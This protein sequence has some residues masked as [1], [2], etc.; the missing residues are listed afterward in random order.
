MLPKTIKCLPVMLAGALGVPGAQASCGSMA[1]EINPAWDIDSLAHDRG[2]RLDLRYVHARADRLRAGSARI[3]PPSPSGSGEEIEDRYTR[4]QTLAVDLDYALNRTWGLALQVPLVR[5]EHAHTLDIVPPEIQQAGYTR[6]G[7]IRVGGRYRFMA[8]DHQWGGGLRLGLKLPTGAT[9]LEMAPGEAME[10]SLQ[11]GT[12]STDA[13]LGANLHWSFP[14]SSWGGFAQLQ[15]QL[16]VD[17]RSGYEPGRSIGV[18]LGLH[19]PISETVTGLVQ[20]SYLH[21]ARD[22]GSL[23][24]PDGNSGGHATYFSPGLSVEVA[25]NTHVYGVIQVPISQY[26]NGEQLT[27]RWVASIGLRLVMD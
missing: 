16:P 18:D 1:C 6:L 5:R 8:D 17:H 7:D 26:V 11:P 12:G 2:L 14:N 15:A 9:G 23:A 25:P 21:R 3:A 24:D 22:K 10:A 13:I 27:A 20:F 19:Y 4:N